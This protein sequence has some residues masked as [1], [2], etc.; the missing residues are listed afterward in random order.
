MPK[1]LKSPYEKV[2]E[3]GAWAVGNISAD[4]GS[5]KEI[6]LKYEVLEPL[7]TKILG[8]SDSEIIK[9]T[10]WALCNL[11]SG[12]SRHL[13]KRLAVAALVK[14]LMTQS[15]LEILQNSLTA[16]L[17]ITD[18]SLIQ[19]LID[20][21]LVQ[22]L[23][24]LMK[25]PEPQILYTILQILAYVT[26]G[27]DDQTQSIIDNGGVTVIFEL[28]KLPTLDHMC[29]RECL[30]IISN[31]LVGTY[32]QMKYIFRNNDWVNALFNHCAHE[33]TKVKREAIW[34]LCNSTKNGDAEHIS[35]LIEK[36]ILTIYSLN[37]DSHCEDSII[38]TILESLSHVLRWGKEDSSV[39]MPNKFQAHLETTGIIDKLETLQLHPSPGIYQATTSL[40]EN[41][42]ILHDPI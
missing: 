39:G 6:L 35:L 1:I 13:K 25:N 18:D 11:V 14:L 33:N 5:F 28:M 29:R 23:V 38:K 16:L 8:T 27:S 10:S 34:S 9:Y 20:S 26:N 12:G 24:N 36:G 32:Q 41:F 19:I 15:D 42:F 22:R 30:W 2:F 4:D 3:Q 21:N 37:L 7:V 17:D 40:L 31:V